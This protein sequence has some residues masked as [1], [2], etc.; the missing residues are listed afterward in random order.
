MSLAERI[1]DIRK[2]KKLSQQELA[3]FAQVHY[4]NIG[5]YERGE[6]NPSS[7]VLNRI[8]QA[9]NVSPD[10]LINGTLENKAENSIS[11]TE[12]L[13]QFRRVEKLPDDKK[14]LIKE[15]LDA[16]LLKD[17]LQQQLAS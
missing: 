6:A 13:N 9:L 11:D 1:K 7:S 2:E 12:L 15:F 8:A 16:F 5:R 17:N 3:D 14:R 10:Y 4:T